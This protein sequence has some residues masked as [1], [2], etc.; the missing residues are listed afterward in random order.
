MPLTSEPFKNNRQLQDCLVRDSAHIVADEAPLCRGENA[1]D[2]HVA[3]IHKGT[4]PGYGNP[5]FGLEEARETYG[6]KTA[7]GV[8]RADTQQSSAPDGPGQHCWRADDRCPRCTGWTQESAGTASGAP[9]PAR[10]N[11]ATAGRQRTFEE[12]FI[13]RPSADLSPD[14]GTEPGSQRTFCECRATRLRVVTSTMAWCSQ[15]ELETSSRL[16]S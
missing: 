8:R 16:T 15:D 9:S 14:S 13:D 6:P 7:E 12:K 1:Q 3:L 10:R 11:G 5:S 4:P 2:A